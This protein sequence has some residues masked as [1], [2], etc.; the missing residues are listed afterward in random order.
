MDSEERTGIPEETG[1]MVYRNHYSSLIEGLLSLVLSGGLMFLIVYVSSGHK[2]AI[3]QEHPWLT[4]VL[5]V[6]LLIAFVNVRVW[7]LT[8]Y[9]FGPTELRVNKTTLFRKETNIQY[10]K[11]ASVN[12][13]RTVINRIFGSTT[14]LFNINSSVN[15]MQAEVTLTLRSDEADR[16]REEISSRIFNKQMVI[17]TERE[18]ESLVKISNFDVILHGFFGQPT[19]S[20]AIGLVFLAYSIISTVFTSGGSFMAFILFGIT[21]V[22]PWIRT[23]LRYY[24]Y[25]IYRIGDTITVESGLLNTYRS[26]FKINKINC[27]RIREPLLARMIGKSLLEA[28]VVGLA[29]T[30][31]LP[32][33]CPLKGRKT[34]SKLAQELVPEF[35]FETS[36]RVQPKRSLVPTLSYKGMFSLISLAAG[37]VGLFLFLSRRSELDSIASIVC[38]IVLATA[39]I[40]I[41]AILMVHGMLAQ[42]GREFEMGDE[43]F[44]FV[45]GAYDRER[46][47]VRY[48]KVQVSSVSSGPIQRRYGVGRCTVS[49]MSSRGAKSITSG[50]FDREELERVGEEIMARI[51]DGR[52]DHRRY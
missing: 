11:M 52:Y 46:E 12:V 15:S 21:T 33:L 8:R 35:I 43:T 2:E 24:N 39:L 18:E 27:V 48:D 14:L 30:E 36:H 40:V 22:L 25:R 7:M 41:P 32:L 34:V 16:L 23:I 28:E 31:G 20:S 51:K 42:R 6:L 47:F 44:M 10:S 50:L 13:R 49:L 17:E 26:S 3:L 1:N 45:I 4:F 38:I 29:D 37:L 5:A 19:A 9:E